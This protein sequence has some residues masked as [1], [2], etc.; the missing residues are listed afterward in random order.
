[1]SSTD[2]V[3]LVLERYLIF[4]II[5]NALKRRAMV[6]LYLTFKPASGPSPQTFFRAENVELIHTACFARDRFS[7]YDFST[8]LTPHIRQPIWEMFK[9]V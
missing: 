5:R 2:S 3:I 7:S 9:A 4:G 6:R 1:M 8:N